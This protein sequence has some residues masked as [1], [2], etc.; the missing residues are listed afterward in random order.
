[1]DGVIAS[2]QNH[3]V[4]YEDSNIRILDVHTPPGTTNSLHD[5]QW[6]SVFLYYE[7]QPKGRD[8]KFDGK[9]TAVGGAVPADASFPLLD[10]SGPQAP[11]AYENMDIFRKHFYRI[12]FKKI[13]FKC[14]TEI[15]HAKAPKDLMDSLPQTSSATSP[16]PSSMDA[17]VASPGNNKV[18]LENDDIRIVEVTILPGKKENMGGH[19]W[20]SALLFYETQPRGRYT[21]EGGKVTEVDRRLEGADF[22]VAVR[23]GPQPPSAFENTD[24]LP[25]H[26]YR[27]EFKTVKFKG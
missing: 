9:V 25:A 14:P 6:S 23:V 3:T 20:T 17:V 7:A 22:P 26:F 8:H 11:H 10:V 1:M 15:Q 4:I 13:P 5:H 19:P 21:S 2:P 18:L 16:W 24:G 27:V 12:E